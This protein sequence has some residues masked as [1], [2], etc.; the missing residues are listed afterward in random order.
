MDKKPILFLIL[1]FLTIVLWFSQ[2]QNRSDTNMD[3]I[4]LFETRI[5]EYATELVPNYKIDI[6]SDQIDVLPVLTYL[7]KEVNLSKG[8]SQAGILKYNWI[9]NTIPET[10]DCADYSGRAVPICTVFSVMNTNDLDVGIEA[11]ENSHES[12][13]FDLLEWFFVCDTINLKNQEKGIECRATLCNKFEGLKLQNYDD[14]SLCER[15]AFARLEFYCDKTT[16]NLNLIVN[17]RPNNLQELDCYFRAY[18]LL[19]SLEG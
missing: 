14:F 15:S 11:L 4:S 18:N 17:F 19:K 1:I 6:S 12:T 9:Q 10:I 5:A 16:D 8:T 2:A 7:E 13:Q 3:N